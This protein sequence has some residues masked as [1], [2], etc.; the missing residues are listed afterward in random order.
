MSTLLCGDWEKFPTQLRKLSCDFL[1][2]NIDYMVHHPALRTA[3]KAM[4]RSEDFVF[5]QALSAV[6]VKLWDKN[7]DREQCLL[8]E[9][10]ICRKPTTFV[11]MLVLLALVEVIK[12]PVTSIYPN[13]NQ[14][15]RLLYHQK[16]V[17]SVVV[18]DS[19]PLFILWSKAGEL[20]SGKKTVF[21]ANHIVPVV[22]G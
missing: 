14:A 22:E 20:D 9:V 17:P 10:Q 6:T 7:K 18:E 5:H 4:R 1:E 11:P 12:R 13:T 15:F 19:T 3:A 21:Q 8:K 16:I 2:N